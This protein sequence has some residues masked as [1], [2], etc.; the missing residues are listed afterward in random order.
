MSSRLFT[1]FTTLIDVTDVF[2]IRYI[3]IINFFSLLLLLR[4][5]VYYFL[6]IEFYFLNSLFIAINTISMITAGLILL[7][8]VHQA[9]FAKYHFLIISLI[10]AL[11]FN[12][13][14]GSDS[15]TLRVIRHAFIFIFISIIFFLGFITQSKENLKAFYT[16]IYFLVISFL[17]INTLL[18]LKL[19]LGINGF[20]STILWLKEKIKV[21]EII[22]TLFICIEIAG[23]WIKNGINKIKLFFALS[24]FIVYAWIFLY[25]YSNYPALDPSLDIMLMKYT[26]DN[27]TAYAYI[28]QLFA[29]IMFLLYYFD[30]GE[31]SHTILLITILLSISFQQDARFNSFLILMAFI[32]MFLPISEKKLSLRLP[33]I[34]ISKR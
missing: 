13:F 34:A 26:I 10:L 3:H 22:A 30:D 29:Y 24:I 7:F 28:F 4:F 12:E 33:L 19:F 8:A 17:L 1:P 5:V 14:D 21:L 6:Y 18:D 15:I 9:Y 27:S 25:L 11:I 2:K 16:F 20:S 31:H 32:S 23:D